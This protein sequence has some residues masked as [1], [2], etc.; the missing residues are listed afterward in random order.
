MV[1]KL[2]KN[3][4]PL[5]IVVA[6]LL[7]AGALIYINQGKVEKV[8]GLLSPQQA[9][10]MAI[11]F[12]NQN[13][14]E[15]GLAAVLVNVSEESGVYKIH[16]K[17]GE[18]EYDSYVTKDGKILFIQGINIEEIVGTQPALP[19][20]EEEPVS[21]E[22]EHSEEKLETL[23]KCL[24]KSGAKFYGT[25][26]CGW[27][28]KQK[29]IFGEVAQY[30]P[31]IECAKAE[32][33]ELTPECQKAGITGFPTWEFNGQKNPGFKTLEELAKLSGCQL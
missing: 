31:Y 30:L 3:L 7:I 5:A 26:W 12:I 19:E 22:K 32:T 16:L 13:L 28:N 17:I 15:E 27:C 10:E 18:D 9:V 21:P 25:Y 14:L 4:I 6:G 29:E 2:K 11:N 24:S 1:E 23:A 33:R 20:K 8:S